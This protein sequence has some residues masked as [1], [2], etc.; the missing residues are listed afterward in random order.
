[1]DND[2]LFACFSQEALSEPNGSPP[3]HEQIKE[4]AATFDEKTFCD[5]YEG[6]FK[7]HWYPIITSGMT[8]FPVHGDLPGELT[9]SGLLQA[10]AYAATICARQDRK[11]FI[12]AL[13]L[14]SLLCR[15]VEKPQGVPS[16][17]RKFMRIRESVTRNEIDP[18]ISYWFSK[19][20]L[21]QLSTGIVPDGYEGTFDRAG[22]N[23]PEKGWLG[24]G[25]SLDFPLVDDCEWQNCPGGEEAVRKEVKGIG[26]G[27]LILEY[28]RN[29]LHQGSKYWIWLYRNV[30]EN[31]SLHWYVY[32]VTTPDG[33][34][35]THKDSMRSEVTKSPEELVAQHSFRFE[36]SMC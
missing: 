25:M 9:E 1:M 28:Q 29:A 23:A 24:Y 12:S 14:L 4:F 15:A 34:T 36:E 2:R 3:F 32:V 7:W 22:L 26:G 8:S 18:N 5:F 19:I 6:R 35:T 33:K 31:P 10:I 13:G 20:A 17:S 16:L 21:Y 27:D 11:R 30:S